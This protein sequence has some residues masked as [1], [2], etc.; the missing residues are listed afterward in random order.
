MDSLYV[1]KGRKSFFLTR[2]CSTEIMEILQRLSSICMVFISAD[3]EGEFSF[4]RGCSTGI[5]KTLKFE[6]LYL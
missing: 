6:A 1:R 4:F 2:G 3:E 5:M